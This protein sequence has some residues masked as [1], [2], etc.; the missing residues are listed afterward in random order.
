[1]P[2]RARGS[3]NT[4]PHTRPSSAMPEAHSSFESS[5]P[6]T[7]TT[8]S[9]TSSFRLTNLPPP[10]FAA[11]TFTFG[12]PESVHSMPF[13]RA[14]HCWRI[15]RVR[16]VSWPSAAS[17]LSQGRGLTLRSSGPSPARHLARKV[18]LSIIGL[19]GQAP[20]RCGPLSSNVRPRVYSIRS[21]RALSRHAFALA[22]VRGGRCQLVAFPTSVPL[23]PPPKHG[24]SS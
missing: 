1:M 17:S 18:V 16:R 23:G 4:P 2:S 21:S 10:S 7:A 6:T 11:P 13:V 8:R 19:A 3:F 12:S 14:A 20:C 9:Q 22:F 24:C 5:V 15:A